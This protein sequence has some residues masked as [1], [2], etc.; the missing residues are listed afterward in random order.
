MD[1]RQA[2]D[3]P[4]GTAITAAH[5]LFEF[6]PTHILCLH[7]DNLRNGY[8]A[9]TDMNARTRNDTVVNLGL[10]QRIN[11]DLICR[12]VAS[13]VNLE[14]L[15]FRNNNVSKLDWANFP[16]LR[17]LDLSANKI[18][19]AEQVS[20]MASR[21][22]SLVML[23]LLKNPVVATWKQALPPNGSPVWKAIGVLPKLRSFNREQ[24]PSETLRVV[25]AKYDN[26]VVAT[27]SA[28]CSHH[29]CWCN[30]HASP[31]LNAQ[32]RA[33][34]FDEAVQRALGP[35][36]AHAGRATKLSLRAM[37]LES[38]FLGS[39]VNVTHLDLS[40][41][42]LPLVLQGNESG[43]QR[44]VRLMVLYLTECGIADPQHLNQLA[45]LPYVCSSSGFPCSSASDAR[46]NADPGTFRNCDWRATPWPSWTHTEPLYCT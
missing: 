16:K 17:Q 40:H 42:T 46:F 31:L 15:Y 12:Q 13:M 28:F 45:N 38:V 41:N 29:S 37:S 20:S 1:G 35:A 21:C 44:C 14:I 19:S 34:L 36:A 23:V 43:I 10:P 2:S 4:T 25:V 24:V 3:F 8:P 32:L 9:G 22:P 18:K 26:R 33:R 6:N 5:A 39:F 11:I 27:A 30:R 7:I